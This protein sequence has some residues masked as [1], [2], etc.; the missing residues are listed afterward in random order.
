MPR[1]QQQ[2]HQPNHVKFIRQ[3]QRYPPQHRYQLQ[4]WYLPNYVDTDVATAAAPTTA[5]SPYPAIAAATNQQQR[6]PLKNPGIIVVFT[7]LL[8]FIR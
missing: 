6:Y 4:Q 2:R 5:A 8:I 1:Q 7:L 3:Q